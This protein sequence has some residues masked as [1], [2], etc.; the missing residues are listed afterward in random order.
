MGGGGSEAG[1]HL[2]QR[3]QSPAAAAFTAAPPRPALH[4]AN[5]LTADSFWL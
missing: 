5:I 4:V 1:S 3:A 2:T